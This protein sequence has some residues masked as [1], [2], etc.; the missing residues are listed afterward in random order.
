[1]KIVDLFSLDATPQ[2]ASCD[3]VLNGGRTDGRGDVLDGGIIESADV[4]ALEKAQKADHHEQGC[5][6]NDP[7]RETKEDRFTA[8]DVC[9]SGVGWGVG[10]CWG[11]TFKGEK[12]AEG[13]GWGV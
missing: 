3:G 13:G 2:A 4:V 1:M 9:G 10:G 8:R 5:G 6:T 7:V 12:G 11:K